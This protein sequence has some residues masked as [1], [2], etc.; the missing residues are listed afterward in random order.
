MIRQPNPSEKRRRG[1]RWIT[2]EEDPKEP[3]SIH[4]MTHPKTD[5]IEWVGEPEQTHP[6]ADPADDH[7]Q[8][9]GEE[10]A[11][12]VETGLILTKIL[13]NFKKTNKANCQSR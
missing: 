9:T 7:H 4:R 3:L 1:N 11:P 2:N 5:F 8:A 10:V 13:M 12:D 6:K